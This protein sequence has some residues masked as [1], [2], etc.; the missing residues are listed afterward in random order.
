MKR[1]T[2]FFIPTLALLTLLTFEACN[3]KKGDKDK[4]KDEERT[5]QKATTTIN[6]EDART[7]ATAQAGDSIG[8]QPLLTDSLI[9]EEQSAIDDNDDDAND[10]GAVW[11]YLGGTYPFS[12][13]TTNVIVE[14]ELGSETAL[15]INFFTDDSDEGD[16]Y[17]GEHD[18]TGRI[19][20]YD[21]D[22]RLVFEGYM[23]QG[24]NMLKGTYKGKSVKYDG[25]GGL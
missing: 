19:R 5:E 11:P 9:T 24:G 10:D 15:T 18:E 4:D 23:Y 7:E 17:E 16:K 2:C 6:D 22:G 1:F 13:G 20:A 21:D 14:T 3:S 12:D 8:E 25:M